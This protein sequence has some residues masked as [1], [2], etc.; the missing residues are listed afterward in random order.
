MGQGC[1]PG[2][3]AP[4]RADTCLVHPC[5]HPAVQ[6]LPGLCHHL[7]MLSC[8]QSWISLAVFF[9]SLSV[10][11]TEKGAP[12]DDACKHLLQCSARFG[13]QVK[14]PSDAFLKSTRNGRN[15][16]CFTKVQPP[17]DV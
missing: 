13:C 10:L 4:A 7:K 6:I 5:R 1:L 2:D 14:I 3:S 15:L 9:L 8:Y 17:K 12:K 16:F 11:G